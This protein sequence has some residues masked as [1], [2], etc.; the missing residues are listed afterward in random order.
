MMDW[1]T[2]HKERFLESRYPLA[3]ALENKMTSG[4]ASKQ[5]YIRAITEICY[6][7]LG[8]V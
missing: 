2:S 6:R 7:F 1:T 5:G 3:E 8:G 4:T